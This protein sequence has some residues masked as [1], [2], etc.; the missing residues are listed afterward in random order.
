MGFWDNDT[1]H[2]GR[3]GGDLAGAFGV[4]SGDPANADRQ[5]L[6]GQ[7]AASG[8]FADQGQQGFANLGAQGQGVIDALKAQ[9]NGQN[10][11]SALQLQQALGQNLAAQ[12]AQA[13]SASPQNAAM[14]MRLAAMNS[15]RL[16]TG[17]AGQQAVAGLQERNQAQ[18]NLAQFLNQ[19]QNMQLQAALQGRATAASGYGNTLGNNAQKSAGSLILG[20][21]TGGAGI[22]SKL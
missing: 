6:S 11:V 4:G 1:F 17:L 10:S 7:A 19:Q 5:A 15:A 13:A 18:Q 20:G 22:A 16:G 3:W 2:P 12:Q 21:I 8:A 9:A 14:A